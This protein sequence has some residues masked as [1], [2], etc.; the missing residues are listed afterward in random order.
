MFSAGK[1]E[2]TERS[3]FTDSCM[4]N[5]AAL[6]LKKAYIF[7]CACSAGKVKLFNLLILSHPASYFKSEFFL[8]PLRAMLDTKLC[9]CLP[10]P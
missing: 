2:N 8:I 6:I 3:K 7:S 5:V 9:I 4:L 10:K 1:H